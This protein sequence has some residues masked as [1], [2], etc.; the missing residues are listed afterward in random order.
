MEHEYVAAADGQGGFAVR[1]IADRYRV[2]DADEREVLAYHWHPIGVSP[3]T[4]PHVHLSGRLVPLDLGRGARSARLG[5][6]HL[7]TG[8]AVSLAEVVRLLIAEF[9]VVPRRSDWEGILAE[10]DR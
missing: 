3:V 2:V 10:A 9:G 5:E 6:M 4:F 8:G 7:P 1:T